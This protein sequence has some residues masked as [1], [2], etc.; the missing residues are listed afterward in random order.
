M[1]VLAVMATAVV[2]L[3]FAFTTLVNEPATAVTLLVVLL[4][5]TVLDGGWKRKR[6][7]R[8]AAG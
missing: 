5:S 8:L 1:L 4:L 3:T 6:D 7:A 2:L